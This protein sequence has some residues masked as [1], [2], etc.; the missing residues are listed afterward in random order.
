MLSFYLQLVE[1]PEEKSLVEQEFNLFTCV[2]E[3]RNSEKVVFL[4]QSVTAIQ[5][6]EKHWTFGIFNPV[7]NNSSWTKTVNSISLSM[8][9]SKSGLSSGTYRVKT[10]FTVTSTNG[11]TE[12]VSVYSDEKTI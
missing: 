11:Q 3:Y 8:T 6:L 4:S 2:T 1:T 5:T 7:D 10:E 9:N 12:T